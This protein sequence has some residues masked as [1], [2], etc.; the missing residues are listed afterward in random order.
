M[1]G[2][3]RPLLARCLALEQDGRPLVWFGLDLIGETV[4]GTTAMRQE[5]ATAL[6]LDLS[7]VIWST[8]QTHSSGALPGSVLT[9]SCITDLS[10]QDPAFMDAERKR[11]MGSCVEAAREALRRR[12]PAVV[13]A[14]RGYCDSVSYNRRFPM[15]T[16][17]VKFS[18][19][20]AEGLQSGK[21]FDTTIGLV[22]FDDLHGKPIGALFNFCAHPATMINDIMISPDWVG[23]ARELVENALGGLPVMYAQGFCGN[24]NCYHIFGTPKQARLTGERLGM[25]AVSAL[26][27]LV[28]VRPG[29]LAHSFKTIEIQCQTMPSRE[30]LDAQLSARLAFIEGLQDDPSATW[31]CGVNLP[32][33]LNPGQK[34]AF[35]G[36][37]VNYLREAIRIME[38]G[39]PIRTTLPL[40]LGALRI[41]DLAAVFSPGENFTETGM[42]IRDR[43]PFAHTLLCGDTN[44][45]FG[46]IATDTEIDR[47]GY[48]ADSFWKMLYVNGFRTAP[49]KGTVGRIQHG[50]AELLKQLS[51]LQSNMA[52]I[53]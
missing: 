22:R 24:V 43:S 20:H 38:A 34:A 36:V 27:N 15:P 41:G 4:E 30:V 9:G 12:V 6:G 35:V 26:P 19:Q 10:L 47:G 13:W 52:G 21:P 51:L 23:T 25:A 49:A 2:L 18:R 50:F 53:E 16:G 17:G 1:T 45:M 3:D 39:E 11:F 8:S 32:E 37:Q 14:G 42:L 5:I 48:E 46:Y 28:P 7:D 44:G 29:P 40:T 31:V 33:Q